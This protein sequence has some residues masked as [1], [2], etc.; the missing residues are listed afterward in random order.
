M[1]GLLV[2]RGRDVRVVTNGQLLRALR[3]R[4]GLSLRELGRL[5]AVDHAYLWRLENSVRIMPS[6]SVI[7]TLARILRASRDETDNL[8]NRRWR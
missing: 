1:R 8:L 3:E 5:A 7:V 4:R 2:G 6:D